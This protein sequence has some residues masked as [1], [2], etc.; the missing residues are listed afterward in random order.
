MTYALFPTFKLNHLEKFNFQSN[1]KR[2]K[3]F[4]GFLKTII[5]EGYEI[6]GLVARFWSECEELLMLVSNTH[7]NTIKKSKPAISA[8]NA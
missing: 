6:K 4:S 7:V 5:A 2:S 3:S 8:I 1:K